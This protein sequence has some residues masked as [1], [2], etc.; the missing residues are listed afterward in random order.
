MENKEKNA[1]ILKDVRKACNRIQ[2]GNFKGVLI[3][4][5]NYQKN[6]NDIFSR[7]I[8]GMIVSDKPFIVKQILNKIKENISEIEIE[9]NKQ[10]RNDMPNELREKLD[11][12]PKEFKDVLEKMV[13]AKANE[14]V[15]K[16]NL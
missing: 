7:G 14:I 8:V 11:S 6:S 9:L 10:L 16:L 13:T 12:L 1:R 3:L 4:S 2:N 15:K 5:E